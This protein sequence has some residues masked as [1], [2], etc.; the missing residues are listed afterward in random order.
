M[1]EAVEAVKSIAAGD[2]GAGAVYAFAFQDR[3]FAPLLE[4]RE[5]GPEVREHLET[6]KP[7]RRSG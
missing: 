2:L 4:D 1:K 7:K 3:D 6:L 5:R